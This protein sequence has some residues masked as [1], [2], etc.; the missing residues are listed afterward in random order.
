MA[1]NTLERR[2]FPEQNTQAYVLRSRFDKW[3]LIK[4]KSFYKAK[5][6]VNIRKWQP[7]D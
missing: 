6:I 5:D 4:M 3:D 1:S 2:K 7:T